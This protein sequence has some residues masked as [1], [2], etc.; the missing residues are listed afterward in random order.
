MKF[1]ISSRKSNPTKAV[2]TPTTATLGR[3]LDVPCLFS[4][5]SPINVLR[6]SCTIPLNPDVNFFHKLEG[7]EGTVSSSSGPFLKVSNVFVWR[8]K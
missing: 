4:G 5:V 2:G 7:G 1:V 8:P 6:R 3:I